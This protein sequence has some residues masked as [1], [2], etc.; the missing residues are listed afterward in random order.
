MTQ[1]KLAELA[2]ITRKSVNA[3]EANRMVPSIILSIMISNALKVPVE[4]LFSLETVN[5]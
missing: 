1:E 4:K 3:I 5:D 2:G